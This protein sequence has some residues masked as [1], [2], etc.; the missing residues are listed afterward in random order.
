MPKNNN[1]LR[2][3]TSSGFAIICWQT[4][5]KEVFVMTVYADVCFFINFA[6]DAEILVLLCKI[7]SKKVPKLRTA[8]V[9]LL[10]GIFGVFPFIPYF[11][12][13]SRMPARFIIPAFMV[14]IVL[15]PKSFKGFLSRYLTFISISFIISG[16]VNFFGLNS[17]SG[18]LI[19]VPV[20][21]LICIL[22]K[23]VRKR[24][25]T[26]VLEYQNKKAV[27]DGFFDSGN[28]LLSGGLPVILGNDKVFA[29]LLGC[30][31]EDENIASF[32]RKFDA[33]I[34]PFISLGR[35]GTVIGVKL[36][37]IWVDGK[38][39]DDVVLAYAGKRFSDEL[40]LNSIMT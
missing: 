19:P 2:Q 14:Y 30:N 5:E 1:G 20:Y 3:E 16:A 27:A 18:L 32:G 29:K 11:E 36:T 37:R 10:G 7:Y 21:C 12:M 40:I 17:I 33:R 22:R 31:M 34:I 9:S 4:K 25:G 13:L 35:A 38:E 24:K 23:N 8:L 6:F 15:I 26:V 39:Y 28:M